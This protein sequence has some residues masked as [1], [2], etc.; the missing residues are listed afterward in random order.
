MLSRARSSHDMPR[1]TN[2]A[3]IEKLSAVSAVRDPRAFLRW[4]A[5]GEHDAA[6]DPGRPRAD[7]RDDHVVLR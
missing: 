5:L 3:A 7:W 6:G 1:V 4:R 2:G